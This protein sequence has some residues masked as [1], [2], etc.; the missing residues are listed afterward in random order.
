MR[1]ESIKLA[2]FKSFIEPTTLLFSTNLTAIVG[3]NGCGKSNIIDAIRWVIGESSARQLRGINFDD[4][5][6]NGCKTR[7]PAGQASVEL[8]F[9]TSEQ[10]LSGKLAQYSALIIRRELTREGQ[11]TYLL[12]G[13]RCRRRDI[14]DIFLGTGLGPNSYAIVEQGMIS[15]MIEAK[16]EVLYTYLEEAAGIS[17]YKERRHDTQLYLT[18]TQANLTRLQ[19]LRQELTTQLEKLQQQAERAQRYTQ[20]K[21]QERQIITRLQCVRLYA[22]QQQMHSKTDQIESLT[23]KLQKQQEEKNALETKKIQDHTQHRILR[24]RIQEI[25]A[26]YYELSTN[27]VALEQ[28][29]KYQQEQAVHLQH[30]Y[31]ELLCTQQDLQQEQEQLRRLQEVTL[32][33]HRELDSKKND[34]NQQFHLE[35][36]RLTKLETELTRIQQ[37]FHRCNETWL[38]ISADIQLIETQEQHRQQRFN[39]LQKQSQHLEQEYQNQSKLLLKTNPQM[40]FEALQAIQTQEKTCQHSLTMLTTDYAE[41]Q[42]QSAIYAQQFDFE[43]KNLDTLTARYTALL[44]LQEEAFVEKNQQAWLKKSGLLQESR[45]AHLLQVE[46]GWELAVERVLDRFLSSI[47]LENDQAFKTVSSQDTGLGICFMKQPIQ[48]KVTS[49]NIDLIGLL[50]KI[51]APWPLQAWLSKVYVADDLVAAQACLHKLQPDELIV[52][53]QGI[54]LGLFWIEHSKKTKATRSLERARSL[55][56]L[57]IQMKELAYKIQEQKNVLEEKQDHARVLKQKQKQSREHMTQ[58]QTQR[59]VLETQYRLAQERKIET[60]KQLQRIEQ[61]LQTYQHELEALQAIPIV[62]KTDQIAQRAVVEQQREEL[63]RVKTHSEQAISEQH[64]RYSAIQESLHQLALRLQA[65]QLQMITNQ[66]RLD[67]LERKKAELAQH[68]ILLKDALI[69]KPQNAFIQSLESL[70]LQQKELAELLRQEQASEAVGQEQLNTLEQAIIACAGSSSEKQQRLEELRLQRQE[71]RVRIETIE[72]KLEE[73]S[74]GDPDNRKKDTVN[75]LEHALQD[76]VRALEEIGPVNLVAQAEYLDIKTRLERLEFDSH[77]LV[78]A[79]QNLEAVIHTIDQET[80]QRFQETLRQMN[81]NFQNLFARLLGGGSSTL[82]LQTSNGLFGIQ[83][84]AQPPGKRTTRIHLLS[85]GEKALTAIALVFA[86]FQLNPAPFC[87][88]DEVDA[89]LDDTNVQRFCNLVQEM[90]QTIQF[91]FIS[92]NKLAIEKANQLAGITMQEAGVSRLVSVDI[93]TALQWQRRSDH[94]VV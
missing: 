18:R 80:Q 79:I 12:N 35:K 37:R 69:H 64:K 73:K 15:R 6:F 24:D 39:D 48:P 77:D 44:N 31:D 90:A 93:E 41:A 40:I 91:I 60:E 82:Q 89:P 43:Q 22:L 36:I 53:R 62:N 87:I 20:L 8:S 83:I 30:K 67:D 4:I 66:Q 14:V 21:Q 9:D 16:P 61:N 5:L 17:R 56:Q 72:E 52:T 25:Q 70:R 1:L 19:D 58:L 3:P 59:A 23:I 34:L 13:L 42:R 74:Q 85:G 55:E 50:E 68:E 32:A 76:V 78:T 81:Q 84:H 63:S 71:L 92:H 46:T 49:S 88:L 10:G 45:L 38:H 86:F 28:N 75:I 65:M 7:K 26:R 29:L 57:Q 54:L 47:F 33:E 2:G 27:I 51:Q 11:S 94:R